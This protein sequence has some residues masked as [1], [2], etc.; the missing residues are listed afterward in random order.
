M[1]FDTCLPSISAGIVF[2]GF[3]KLIPRLGQRSRA[4][5]QAQGSRQRMKDLLVALVVIIVGRTMLNTS[6]TDSNLSILGLIIMVMSVSFIIIGLLYVLRNTIWIRNA[7]V[8]PPPTLSE[9]LHV[10]D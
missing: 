5:R 7:L 8:T 9:L 3:R 6:S 4:F 2:S 1:L 10:H